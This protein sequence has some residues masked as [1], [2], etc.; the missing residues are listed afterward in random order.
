MDKRNSS[1]KLRWYVVCLTTLFAACALAAS[2]EAILND[3]W[4]AVLLYRSIPL[5]AIGFVATNLL[6]ILGKFDS[7]RLLAG[8]LSIWCLG[9]VVLLILAALSDIKSLWVVAIGDGALLVIVL[10]PALPYLRRHPKD[11]QKPPSDPSDSEA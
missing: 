5:A 8:Y 1:R 7:R 3:L 2:H 10:F 6:A 9:F 4:G 11:D